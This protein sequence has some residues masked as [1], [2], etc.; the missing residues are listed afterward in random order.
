MIYGQTDEGEF[1][2]MPDADGDMWEQDWPVPWSIGCVLGVCKWYSEKLAS[3]GDYQPR[4]NGKKQVGVD[5]RSFS[6]GNAFESTRA[7]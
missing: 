3:N 4:L 6:W 7:Y 2:L 5:G 1:Y